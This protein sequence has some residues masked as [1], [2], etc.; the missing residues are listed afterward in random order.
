MSSWQ[1][2]Y[3]FPSVNASLA[4]S[5]AIAGLLASPLRFDGRIRTCVVIDEF[6]H[7]LDVGMEIEFGHPYE[8]ALGEF[9]RDNVS[10]STELST[11]YFACTFK[12]YFLPAKPH[13]C[14]GWPRSMFA[15][16]T[17][18]FKRDFLS[19]IRRFASDCRASFVAVVEDPNDF[20]EDRLFE[21]DGEYRFDLGAL[22]IH[23]F[24]VQEVWVHSLNRKGPPSGIPYHHPQPLPDGFVRFPVAT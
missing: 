12:M 15:N 19:T 10:F 21:I 17:F 20:F 24:G 23:D 13:V 1:F 16:A 5:E 11:D 8:K 3:M 14:F 4:S 7:L 9:I 2:A 18:E 6:G 22:S